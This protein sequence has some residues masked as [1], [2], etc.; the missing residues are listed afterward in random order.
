MAKTTETKA[1]TQV[2]ALVQLTVK[3]HAKFDNVIS[4]ATVTSASFEKQI[5]NL[6]GSVFEDFEG[7]K[8]VST[9]AAQGPLK[10]KLYFKPVM[11]KTDGGL[12]AVKV[13]GEGVTKPSKGNKPLLSDMVNTIN[14]L[15]TSKQF[16]LEDTA[17]ELLAEYLMISD[18]KIVDRYNADLDKVVK[19]RLP[20]NWNQYTEEI[21][22]PVGNTRY[23]NPY[24]VVTLDLLPIVAKLY[25]KKEE[26][27]VKEFAA[28]GAIPKDR[29]QYSVSIVKV[30]NPTVGSYILEIRRIDTR[31]LNELAQ[32][33][34]YGTVSGNIVMTRK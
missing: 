28:K 27:E 23:T 9:P 5:S 25:G 22:D 17:K 16:E 18:A 30:L 3:D 7:C 21:V 33:I 10:V 12:Y 11:N 34:G 20:K 1:T 2:P 29:Y 13:R 26:E 15:A 6:F 31:A 24:L 32:S 19:V 14:M 4:T 8:I